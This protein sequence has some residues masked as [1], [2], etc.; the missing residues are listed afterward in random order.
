MPLIKLT[1]TTKHS[2]SLLKTL[3]TPNLLTFSNLTIHG[4]GVDKVLIK[5]PAQP[6][7]RQI[8]EGDFFITLPKNLADVLPGSVLDK[9]DFV[10]E[11]N[12]NFSLQV[13][14]TPTNSHA[15]KI[16]KLA[17]I[18]NGFDDPRVRADYQQQIFSV[19]RPIL[20]LQS[21]GGLR[22]VEDC[23]ASG[24]TIVGIL[25]LLAGKSQIPIKGKKIR[26][27][28][29]VAT[30]QGT[31]VLKKFA[32]QNNLRIE[33]NV[34]YLA[35]GLSEGEK[36]EGVRLHANYIIYP[37]E[38]LKQLP[39]K[40]R[41][42]LNNYRVNDRNIYVVGDMGD[43]AKSLPKDFDEKYP[44]NKYR[45]DN[46]G[47]KKAQKKTAN[48]F[49]HKKPSIIYLTNGGFLMQAYF[50]YLNNRSKYNNLVFSAKRVWSDDAIYGYGVLI[51]GIPQIKQSPLSKQAD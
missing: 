40:I 51:R 2:K 42:E 37:E 8:R 48:V 27:D 50:D 1:M 16:S 44:W 15:L 34:G 4:N 25:T 5:D 6:A 22:I 47:D 12:Q 49:N 36:K 21:G 46:H 35:Y 32:E 11:V 20:A 7:G 33:I 14:Y 39:K 26:I 19:M 45:N 29:A 10:K 24:D 38:I 18:P 41:F 3:K 23:L 17:A 43:A 30:T 31:F 9:E 13:F 28:V